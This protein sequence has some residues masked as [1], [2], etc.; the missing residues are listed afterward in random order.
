MR[1]RFLRI[2]EVATDAPPYKG[3]I[4]RIV[5]LL[6]DGFK[7][8]GHVVDVLSPRV[9]FK[10]LKVSGIPFHRYNDYDIIHLHGPTPFLSDL[11]LLTNS[12]SPIVY[13]HHAEIGWISERLSKI[14]RDFHRFLSRRARA[15]IVHSYDYG[16]LFNDPNVKVVRM[17]CSFKPPKHVD[18]K[19]KTDPFT[20][21]YVG[22]FRPFKGIEV[23]VRSAMMLKDVN[24]ILVGDGYSRANLMRMAEGLANV[25]FCGTVSDERLKSFY[26]QAHVV[27]LPA[28]N[29]TEA[30]GLVLIEGAL[31]GCLPLAS[32]LIGVRENIAQLRGLLFRS[33]SH[34]SLIE[35]I[36]A[37]VKDRDLFVELAVRSQRAAT[38]YAKTYTPDYY[39]G[40]HLEIFSRCDK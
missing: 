21:L 18:V 13:T 29:T 3:G 15:I 37:L 4:S 17:P 24:F 27:S 16:S 14:Y 31:F 12:Q 23:L 39:V 5:G 28:I 36:N 34:K 9:R 35:K 40:R 2:L 25:E 20:V 26:K 8:Q 38:C 6:S 22:Q 10:E 1:G 32:N 19:E 33:K 11:L 7:A 30:Y